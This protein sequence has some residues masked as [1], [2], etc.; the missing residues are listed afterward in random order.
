MKKNRFLSTFFA[1]MALFVASFTTS[2]KDDV[3]TGYA[4]LQLSTDAIEFDYLGDAADGSNGQ[5]TI[6]HN[7]DSWA[8]SIPTADQSWLS[9]DLATGTS[10]KTVTFTASETAASRSTTVTVYLYG[11][12]GEELTKQTLAISQT[13][14]DGAMSTTARF[15][16]SELPTAYSDNETI[17]VG[18]VDFMINHV[19]NYTSTNE[20]AT[21]PI[22][23]K[24]SDSYLYNQSAFADLQTV[25]ITL[26][27][28]YN[29][30]IVYAGTEENPTAT[31]VE[32]STSGST[33]TYT[34][35]EG[36]TYVSIYN[37]ST[38]ASYAD[39]IEFLCGNDESTAGEGG[40][41]G[42]GDDSGSV[43][44]GEGT[45]ADGVKFDGSELPTT[46]PTNGTITMGEVEFAI[47]QVA[48]F[49]SSYE[50]TG[51]IQF[52]SALGYL[53]NNTAF[54]DL[55]KIVITLSNSYNNF[56]VY[57][58]TEAN[59]GGTAIE[60]ETDGSTVT[61]TLPS[62]T[63]H[64]AV[65]NEADY[66][67]YADTIEFL[68]GDNES[69]GG[70]DNTGDSGD[71]S[72]DLTG[73]YLE[74][75][76]V[77]MG[78]SGSSLSGSVTVDGVDFAYDALSTAD[79]YGTIYIDNDSENSIYGYIKNTTALS[80]VKRL[81]IEGNGYVK[82]NLV[83]KAG[84][85][86]D[87]LTEITSGSA[88]GSGWGALYGYTIPADAQYFSFEPNTT[89][90][91]D[92]GVSSIAFVFDETTTTPDPDEPTGDDDIPTVDYTGTIYAIEFVSDDN[93]AAPNAT[94]AQD[95]IFGVYK[96]E[97]AKGTH[98]T[99]APKYY[100]STSDGETIRVYGGNTL[101]VSTT[102]GSSITS[103]DF[104][105]QSSSY[106]YFSADTGSYDTSAHSWTGD[107]TS[108]TFTSSETA[109]RIVSIVMNGDAGEGGDDNTGDDSGETMTISNIAD[110]VVGTEC[111]VEGTIVAA[112][113]SSFVISDA[114]GSVF[115]YGGVSNHSIGDVITMQ[116]TPTTYNNGIQ[117]SY[118]GSTVTT[119]STG[120][121]V[122]YPTPTTVTSSNIEDYTTGDIFAT[123][124]EATGTLSSVSGNYGTITLDG[125][126]YAIS[127]YF[128]LSDFGLSSLI[129]S[130]VKVSGYFM[131]YSS[132]YSCV[133]LVVTAVEATGNSDGSVST[134]TILTYSSLLTA[135]G[136]TADD[137]SDTTG[138]TIED[139]VFETFSVTSD[140]GTAST[141]FRLWAKG[142]SIRSYA[143]NT[144]TV[145]ADSG[146]TIKSIVFDAGAISSSDVGTVES[147][148]TWSGDA[149]EVTLTLEK[150]TSYS[151]QIVCE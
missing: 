32:A 11:S 95:K 121:S 26:S 29:N 99:L 148:T 131:S 111:K 130:E 106:E 46:Y 69:S 140:K 8:I 98:G 137:V 1:V 143:G 115:V 13:D 64:A 4:N 97:W 139:A 141:N 135:M 84:P 120:E 35:P 71:E 79:D 33:V 34:V 142:E 52:K 119:V 40:S 136:K 145:T 144:F 37:T 90:T 3:D 25:V 59:P 100:T 88:D 51:P 67:A 10:N 122:T 72:T 76:N 82:T 87:S 123:Y 7:R 110:M 108:I 114:S 15:D 63:T 53:Y 74:L 61:Y 113:T 65:Y 104:D 105:M 28:S 41:T 18:G 20:T 93:L 22:Q 126:T 109:T 50:V 117:L 138:L 149:S 31:E 147:T 55:T 81:V 21:G 91:Y 57:A 12:S 146:Y 83:V 89:S 43:G 14:P 44:G 101:T 17:T 56:T 85:T 151:I 80:G 54:E 75:T 107:A 128:A 68:C 30:F 5:V 124:V 125:A 39:Y 70:D 134:T 96:F 66:T 19:A 78:I 24:A 127:T 58:G 112:T 77:T 45:V 36:T 6:S 94:E 116:G 103:I 62:G 47:N 48:N 27:G 132:S 2:C 73:D 129:G 9:V 49:S 118:S 42:G 23:F 102:D 38:Y 133:Y 60:G 150:A 16:G 92:A 86:A